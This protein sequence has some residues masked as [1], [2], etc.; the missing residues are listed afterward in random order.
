MIGTVED[1]DESM[2]MNAASMICYKK[3]EFSF[4]SFS[5]DCIKLCLSENLYKD[6][7]GGSKHKKYNILKNDNK[8]LSFT[9]TKCDKYTNTKKKLLISI[10]ILKIMNLFFTI[11]LGQIICWVLVRLLLYGYHVSIMHT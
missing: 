4:K 2:R 10:R 7:K 9:K 5:V 11:S 3:K 8:E 1:N 6:V